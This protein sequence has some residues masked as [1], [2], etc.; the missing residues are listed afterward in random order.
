[1][2]WEERDGILGIE[3]VI[4]SMKH[5]VC[6]SILSC[7]N[8]MPVLLIVCVLFV[9]YLQAIITSNKRS[10]EIGTTF[11]QSTLVSMHLPP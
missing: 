7:A 6:N 10:A 9:Q 5:S 11:L 8:K 4:R 1:M 3:W 2:E